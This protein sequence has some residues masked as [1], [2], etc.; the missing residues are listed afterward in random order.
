LFVGATLYDGASCVSSPGPLALY[1]S[2]S[3]AIRAT[4]TYRP[5]IPFRPSRRHHLDT[6]RAEP[7]WTPERPALAPPTRFRIQGITQVKSAG[8]IGRPALSPSVATHR[9]S[10]PA[11]PTP[12]PNRG[13]RPPHRADQH[14]PGD[15]AQLHDCGLHVQ[16]VPARVPAQRCQQ[17]GR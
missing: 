8:V 12:S 10:P 13:A 9:W 3:S 15:V 4:E 14:D 1:C 2:I 5:H 16:R 6:I 7:P 11:P 17:D